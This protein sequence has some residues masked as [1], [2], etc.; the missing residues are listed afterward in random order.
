M[1]TRIHALTRMRKRNAE[2]GRE[3]C[4]AAAGDREPGRVVSFVQ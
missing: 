2:G 4:D 3:R 1:I